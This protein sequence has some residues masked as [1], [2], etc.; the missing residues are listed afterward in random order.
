METTLFDK[1]EMAHK[2]MFLLSGQ[3]TL[4]WHKMFLITQKIIK[5]CFVFTKKE[6]VKVIFLMHP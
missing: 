1:E 5:V 3:I 4:S 6:F 2:L